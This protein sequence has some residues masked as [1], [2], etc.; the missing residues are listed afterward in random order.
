MAK[1]FNGID[2]EFTPKQQ[3]IENMTDKAYNIINKHY[4]EGGNQYMDTFQ[5]KYDSNDAEVHNKLMNDTEVVIL[6]NQ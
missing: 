4:D 1:I 3:A 2:W 6:N 5:E